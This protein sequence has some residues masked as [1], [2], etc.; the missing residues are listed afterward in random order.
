MTIAEALTLIQEMKPNQYSNSV[1]LGWL[2]ELDGQISKSIH[3]DRASMV[4]LN[5][6]YT[7]ETPQTTALL[8][9]FPFDQIYLYWLSAKVDNANQEFD[10]YM[11]GMQLF[12]S[13]YNAYAAYVANG[14]KSLKS[15]EI[16][17]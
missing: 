16:T 7:S 1:M 11:N 8:V 14:H 17:V 3:R 13:Y 2:S 10:R 9:P 12:N 5:A 6:P 4:M 15:G